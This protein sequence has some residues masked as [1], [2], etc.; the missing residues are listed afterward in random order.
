MPRY[1][2]AA[3]CLSAWLVSLTAFAQLAPPSGEAGLIARGLK[4]L[5]E[6]ALRVLMTNQTLYHTNTDTG[7]TYPIYYRQ[8]GRRFLKLGANVRPSR[9]LLRDGL[10]CDESAAGGNLIC[11][12]IF[13]EAGT[14][15]ACAVGAPSCEWS[16]TAVA[17]DVE[18]ISR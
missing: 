7:K 5:D 18:G 4:P 11:F 6:A 2:R 13:D 17:G 14:L 3:F 10:R 16:F 15:R 12:R 8:D 9:W 1:L